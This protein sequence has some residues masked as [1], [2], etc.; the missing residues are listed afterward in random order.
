[1]TD[2]IDLGGGGGTTWSGTLHKLA[3]PGLLLHHITPTKDYF[4][5][6]LQPWKHYVP[7]KPDLAD[8]KAKYDWAQSHQK[9]AF[10]IARNGSELMRFLSS[11]KGMEERYQRDILDPLRAVIN[12]Y[13]P[14]SSI[15]EYQDKTWKEVLIQKEGNGNILPILKCTGESSASCEKI[16]GKEAF[17]DR[18]VLRK[19]TNSGGFEVNE[20]PPQEI[21]RKL[22]PWAHN[23][24]VDINKKPDTSRETA[25]FW[26]IP[27][28]TSIL[29]CFV[30]NPMLRLLCSP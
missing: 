5:D 17:L 28:V 27:K 1:M 22:Q 29:T 12:A 2:H 10:Q 24:F 26:H 11:P 13:D 7:V 25:L 21:N 18:K 30:N 23:F 9:K 16:V 8:L 20:S 14:I 15:E 3:F 4:H 19:F 6:W